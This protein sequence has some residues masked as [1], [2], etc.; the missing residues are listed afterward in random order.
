RALPGCLSAGKVGRWMREGGDLRLGRKMVFLNGARDNPLTA[1]L[2]FP[3]VL[4]HECVARR[5]DTGE[6]VVLDPWLGCLP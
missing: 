6:V 5:T 1:L 3:H 4:G 2:S